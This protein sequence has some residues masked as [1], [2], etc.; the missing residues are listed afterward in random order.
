MTFDIFVQFCKIFYK[1]KQQT[2][3]N[4]NLYTKM[5]DEI[6]QSRKLN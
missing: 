5:I 6:G 3:T 4:Q 1:N 2:L